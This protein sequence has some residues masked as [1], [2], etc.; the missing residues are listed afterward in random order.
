MNHQNIKLFIEL[1]DVKS[2]SLVS[3]GVSSKLWTTNEA[4]LETWR[5]VCIKTCNWKSISFHGF[6][7]KNVVMANYEKIK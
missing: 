6:Y 2:D 1:R 5:K 4:H 3:L 7:M